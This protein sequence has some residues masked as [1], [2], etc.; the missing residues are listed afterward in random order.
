MSFRKSF[1]A[2]YIGNVTLRSRKGFG[3]YDKVTWVKGTKLTEAK[4]AKLLNDAYDLGRKEALQDIAD[5][6]T[7]VK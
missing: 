7:E 4:M 6:I 3:A 5:R 1:Y 2:S